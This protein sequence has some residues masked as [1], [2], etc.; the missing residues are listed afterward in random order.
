MLDN[1][2]RKDDWQQSALEGVVAEDV[3]EAR[4]DDHAESVVLKRPHRV[5]A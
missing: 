1:F 2:L 3:A 4:G 5:L